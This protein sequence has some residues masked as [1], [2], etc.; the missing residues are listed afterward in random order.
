MP[1]D[2]TASLSWKIGAS[3]PPRGIL[4]ISSIDS[5]RL[6]SVVAAPLRAI[7]GFTRSP[8]Q[9]LYN[10]RKNPLWVI[11]IDLRETFR[12]Y[13]NK[14]PETDSS[15]F[16]FVVPAQHKDL[17]RIQMS[18]NLTTEGGSGVRGSVMK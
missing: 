16:V 6:H 10:P 4:G 12:V 2:T 15:M 7:D 18:R 13:D 17:V 14:Y 1:L 5:R 3:T 9:F 11:Q 8:S